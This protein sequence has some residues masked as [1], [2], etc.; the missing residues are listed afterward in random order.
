MVLVRNRP[1]IVLYAFYRTQL[2][3]LEGLMEFHHLTYIHIP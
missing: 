3:L 2:L 1:G